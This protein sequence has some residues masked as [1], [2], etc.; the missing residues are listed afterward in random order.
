MEAFAKIL[1]VAGFTVAALELLLCHGWAR[2]YWRG[3]A[4]LMRR[5]S[6]AVPNAVAIITALTRHSD[7]AVFVG[8]GAREIQP[9]LIALREHTWQRRPHLAYYPALRG[10]LILCRDSIALAF[11]PNLSAIL[12]LSAGVVT[13]I[14]GWYPLLIGAPILFLVLSSAAIQAVR[15]RG[16]LKLAATAGSTISGTS[17]NQQPLRTPTEA[18]P[19]P[20]YLDSFR[21]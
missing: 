6:D 21:K 10:H 7:D 3:P 19:N 18:S 4:V 14:A 11:F 8:F 12:V 9:G 5:R 16:L 17:P 15:L 1:L 20:S 2:I 13:V